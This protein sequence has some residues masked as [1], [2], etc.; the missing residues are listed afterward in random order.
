MQ[1][2]KRISRR[3]KR[4][5]IVLMVAAALVLMSGALALQTQDQLADKVVRLHVLANS[6]S[7]EDQAL[8]LRVRD[9]VL[10]RATELLEQSADRQE[11]EALLR[12][13]LLELENLAAEEIAAAGYDYPVTA[14]LTDTTFPTREYDGF[15]LP[16]GEYLALRIVIGEGAGQNWWCVVFPPLCTTASADVPASALAAGLTQED[17]N[18]ITEEPGYVLK[19]KTVELWERLRA[20]LEG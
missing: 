5:E 4:V 18:L 8:K 15:T 11:A 13:N 14:E 1:Q 2:V 17:V 20:A 7:E 19:F 6:D 12:G 9:R 16:A 10:E 3:L